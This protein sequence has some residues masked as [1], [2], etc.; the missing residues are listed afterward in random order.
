MQMSTIVYS[1]R[2]GIGPEFVPRKPAGPGVL[3]ITSGQTYTPGPAE[4]WDYVEIQSGGT[5]LAS[6][7][8]ATVFNVTTLI[9]LPGGTLDIGTDAS[10]QTGRFELVFRDVPIN[11]ATDPFQWGNGLLNFGTRSMVAP[12]KDAWGVATGSVLQGATSI[13]LTA[14]P[15]NWEV[16][17]AILLPD[18]AP[19]VTA[20]GSSAGAPRRETPVTIT[21][22]SG[23]TLTL[24]KPLDFDHLNIADPNGIVILSPRVFNLTRK[25]I[26]VHSENP[27]GTRGH[28]A[29]I[30]L[31][32]M[33]DVCYNSTAGLG[34]TTI[35]VLDNTVFPADDPTSPTAP[36]SGATSPSHIGTNEIARYN[37][38]LHHCG[39]VPMGCACGNVWLGDGAAPYAAKWA[40][41]VH[42][43]SD[44]AVTDNIGVDFP[45]AVFVTEDG[46]EV[47]NTFRHNAALYC[48]T[49]A[50]D[51]GGNIQ[52]A[53]INVT[54]GRPGTEGTGFWMH[55]VNNDFQYNESWNGFSSGFNLFNQQNPAGMLYPSAPGAMP[56]TPFP[57][58]GTFI[59]TAFTNNI[60]AC[61]AIRGV[62]LWA[63]NAFP[64]VGLVSCYNLLRQL[65]PV[66]SN[67]VA[68]NLVNA[69]LIGHITGPN[70]VA[71][72][73]Y[74]VGVHSSTGYVVS[75]VLTGGQIAGNATGIEGGGS[76]S[77]LG[78]SITGTTL[79]NVFNIPTLPQ[80]VLFQDVVHVPLGTLPHRYIGF[81]DGSV[82]NGTDPLPEPGFS[83]WWPQVGSR[84]VVKNWQGTGQDYLLF[85]AQSLGHT[86]AWYS[87]DTDG[88]SQFNCPVVGLTMQQSWNQFGLSWGGGVLPDAEAATLDGLV[89]GYAHAGLT[90]AFPPPRAIVTA[91]TL[92]HAAT[93][94]GDGTVNLYAILTGDPALASNILGWSIDGGAPN[95][96]AIDESRGIA[97]L[98]GP[99]TPG[100]HTI[101]V[102]RTTVAD[103]TVT[104]P[105][106][107]YVSEYV[108]GAV[109]TTTVPN[110][111]GLTQ[112]AATSALTAAGL[113]VGTITSA[114]DSTVTAGLVL[115]ESPVAGSV[116]TPGEAINLVLSLGP[117]PAWHTVTTITG[118]GTPVG[119]SLLIQQFGTQDRYRICVGDLCTELTQPL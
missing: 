104:I 84:F 54:A 115:T 14:A 55:G 8:V 106:S 86:A 61:H 105:A 52:Q 65:E 58:Y 57:L 88:V 48:Y 68:V 7:T 50:A 92:R 46:N 10:P 21:A 35:G 85:Y 79:Q 73:I 116:S 34:R 77:P 64:I 18:T 11:T 24:S 89:N 83:S 107:I 31:G 1:D 74:P 91:P 17:D 70:A 12:S 80:E 102:W 53:D 32:I 47:R 43:T 78:M 117:Q 97:I 36:W 82:W 6:R 99:G 76:G 45:G 98:H 13:T 41:S 111:V 38:H 59:P 93:V 108:V 62:E 25:H 26:Y 4:T 44:V 71:G 2:V 56:D 100:T 60:S 23:A 3:L 119:P 42:Q 30:G 16:G 95:T 72:A 5:L 39:S 96:S 103:P 63:V 20:S 40:I 81:G 67:N 114:F 49:Y 90:T 87:T 110:V 22:I 9:V 118:D 113:V 37:D 28:Q 66:L 51:S 101:T 19:Q 94:G 75:F 109:T 69:K 15:L 27:A 112:A 33:R 29:D